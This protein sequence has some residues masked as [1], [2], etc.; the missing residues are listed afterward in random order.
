MIKEGTHHEFSAQGYENTVMIFKH[1]KRL[2]Q[3]KRERKT[4]LFSFATG[5][6]N[7]SVFHRSMFY[8]YNFLKI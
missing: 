8:S 2:K 5:L 7:G 6:I 3:E 1:D 4:E